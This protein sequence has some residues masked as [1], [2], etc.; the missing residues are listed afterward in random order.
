[1]VQH[2]VRF[3]PEVRASKA[4]PVKEGFMALKVGD[5]F[6]D[7][8]AAAKGEFGAKWPAVKDL[9]Q[10]QFKEL[11][12]NLARIA[13]L[14]ASGKVNEAQ[15]RL[16]L[17]IHKN[18]TQTLLLSIEG[19]GL[20]AVESAVNAALNVVKDAVNTALGFALV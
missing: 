6:K 12:R 20:I 13:D 16:L 11:A 19:I 10:E 1:L 8:L 15:A 18:A 14:F 2:I 3:D 7:M 9:A 17:G 4:P 5:L